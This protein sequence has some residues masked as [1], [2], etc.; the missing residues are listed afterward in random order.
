[1]SLTNDEIA[2]LE[3][4]INA[5]QECRLF[6]WNKTFFDDICKQYDEK[7]AELFLTLKQWQNLERLYANA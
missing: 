6:G 3:E 5:V 4:I 1:M 2:R 7:G